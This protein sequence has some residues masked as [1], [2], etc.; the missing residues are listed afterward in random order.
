[1]NPA[2]VHSKRFLIHEK[3]YPKLKDHSPGTEYLIEFLLT[4]PGKTAQFSKEYQSA[5][6]PQKGTAVDQNLF[7]TLN[8]LSDGIVAGVV[9]ILSILLMI[10]AILCLRFTILATL[11]E[12]TR[13]I[14]VMKAI[15]IGRKDIRRIYVAKYV[16]MT[17]FAS[18]LGY[19]GSILLKQSVSTNL[20][21]YL[22][23]GPGQPFHHL[24]PILTTASLSLVIVVSC[25]VVLRRLSEIS[26]VEALRPMNPGETV[27]DLP[28][29]KLSRR[30]KIN[31]NVVLGLRDVL[32][33]LRMYT[34]LGF[35]FF[36]CTFVILVPVNFLSTMQSSSFISYMGIGRSD[37]RID[38]RQS[39]NV[40]SRFNR[41]VTYLENDPDVKQYAPL[42]TAPYSIIGQ[43]GARETLNIET[44]DLSKFPLNY[45]KGK[46]PQ[47]QSEIA[48]SSLNAKEMGKK[49]GDTIVLFVDGEKRTM[50]ITGIYQDVTH[51]GRT[52]K[53]NL[54]FK[55]EQALWYT[56]NLD[57]KNSSKISQKIEEYS[58]EFE[59]AR[60]TDLE[61]YLNQTLG[62]TI[63]Q[64]KT[65]TM[66]AVG[67]GLTVAALITSLFL[68]MLIS[69][70]TAQIGVM[71][72]LGFSLRAVRIQYLSRS[73]FLLAFG[74]LAG[75]LFSNTVGQ[76]LV[77]AIW[78]Y[79]GASQ[80]RFVINPLRAYV[81]LPVLLMFTVSLTTAVTLKGI[82]ESNLAALIKG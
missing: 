46:T 57:V 16:V 7:R 81:L 49:V 63:N 31:I 26:A 82:Q 76:Q 2:I 62:N 28:L 66:V 77:S 35:I 69:K 48:L 41:M 56:V 71:R 8:G 34:L 55:T 14:G 30:K 74:I 64:L 15:G 29:L 78:S 79:M 60:V 38:L 1:M 75:T 19:L 50:T 70:D 3:D 32:Q 65:A 40:S 10:I 4:D 21:L 5:G 52:A 42:V 37:I 68:N 54:P 24:I 61:S 25:L 20:T 80:I 58:E 45:Q 39:D 13:E 22:G 43:E 11:E 51:G 17:G 18:V 23:E 59:P 73:L 27:K 36:F 44:G 12:D 72:S 67:V 47:T 33:R 53:A 9:I 6:L